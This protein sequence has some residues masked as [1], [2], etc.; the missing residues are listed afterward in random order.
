MSQKLAVD[1]GKPVRD[2]LLPVVRVSLDERELKQVQSVFDARVF[3]SVMPAANKVKQLEADF[4]RYVGVKHAV[5]FSS[6][7]TAQH[8]SLAAGDIGPGDEV[9]VPP[10]TFI[11]T[12]YTVLIRNATVV[13]ADVDEA[14]FNLDPVKVAEKITPRTRAIVPVHWFGHPVDMDPL[15]ALADA[16]GLTVIEDCAHAF[17][18]KYK[19]HGAG[20]MGIMACWSLQESKLITSAGEGGM[21]T[22]D[23]A[24]LADRART[25]RDH[26]KSQSRRPGQHAYEVVAVGNNYRMTEM[27]AAFGI[28]QLEKIDEFRIRRRSQT[29]FLDAAF[30]AIPQI[31]LQAPQVSTERAYSYY[32]IRVLRDRMRVDLL[33]VVAAL[34]A[35]GIGS[36]AI[37][38]HELCHVHPLFVERSEVGQQRYGYGTLPIA[39]RIADELL[40]LP[41]Y[42]DLTQQDLSDIVA[43]V[44][45]VV[46]AY[47]V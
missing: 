29:E 2:A 27:Q 15:L 10:L 26:G 39:E 20:T 34:A 3:C 30:S 14:T 44:R 36:S 1:G 33:Q 19:G 17:G 22:T 16:H 38:K 18:T 35:E 28:A 32:P 24:V 4:A 5:A 46:A 8:A 47:S 11:S 21:L 23:D 25:M 13:F 43:A 12:A 41:L 37:G 45:K 40:V 9:I 31:R 42:P 6:G 7:T